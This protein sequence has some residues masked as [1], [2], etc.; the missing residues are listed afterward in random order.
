LCEQYI[1]REFDE[2]DVIALRQF[3]SSLQK[4]KV[5]KPKVE[6]KPEKLLSPRSYV[7]S[8]SGDAKPSYIKVDSE[9]VDTSELVAER[10]AE[11]KG[12]GV[13]NKVGNW[14]QK[15]TT[16]DTPVSKPDIVAERVAEV[17]GNVK[18]NERLG[19]WK[20]KVDGEDTTVANTDPN[21]KAERLAEVQGASKVK[22]RLGQW[23][24]KAEGEDASNSSP[25][26]VSERLAEVRGS[27]KLK[28]RL[29]NWETVSEKSVDSSALVEERLADLKKNS[30]VS[31]RKD[32]W[33]KK[34]EPETLATNS[35]VLAERTSEAKSGV[36][37]KA[38]L[39][40]WNDTINK[41]PEVQARKEPIK[42]DY[43]F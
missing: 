31:Q 7:P 6:K 43:G 41:E 34:S 25:E 26:K 35:S 36:S 8:S 22:D 2:D 39:S 29:G 1:A 19:A 14:Q 9:E 11:I 42:I 37:L 20:A 16:D 18:V 24:Q 13:K 38:K 4:Q 23:N 21:L 30:S 32:T 33:S 27:T 3:L 40:Q 12:V 5:L 10:T 15:A 28:D 17:T